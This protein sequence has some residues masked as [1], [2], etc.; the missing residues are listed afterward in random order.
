MAGGQ[1][2]Q[3]LGQIMRIRIMGQVNHAD[4]ALVILAQG[5]TQHAPQ[6]AQASAGCQQPQRP[7]LPV[8][9]IVQRPAAQFAQ[10]QLITRL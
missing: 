9:V 3:G 4:D 7:G 5:L 2:G 10:A 8:R 1:L 6:R